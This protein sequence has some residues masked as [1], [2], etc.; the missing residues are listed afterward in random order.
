MV[1][2]LEAGDD[3]VEALGGQVQLGQARG[4]RRDTG[5]PVGD[6]VGG[7]VELVGVIVG[8]A[9]GIGD[10]RVGVAHGQGLGCAVVALAG[11]P[12]LATAPLQPVDVGGHRDTG[13]AQR[14]QEGG[15]GRVEDEGRIRMSA[16]QQV[17]H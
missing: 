2:H 6:E 11:G 8:D 16:A 14:G 4:I 12:P 9:L 15:V 10:E 3:Q 7:G 17:D 13:G 1:L 5:R